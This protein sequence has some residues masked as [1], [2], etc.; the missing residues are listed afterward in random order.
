MAGLTQR[1]C[2]APALVPTLRVGTHAGTLCVVVQ[3]QAVTT[4]N[5][6]GMPAAPIW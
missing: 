2:N 5:N 6:S 4:G 1:S 3:R